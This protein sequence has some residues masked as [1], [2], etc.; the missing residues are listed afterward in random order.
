[1]IRPAVK[2]SRGPAW[3]TPKKSILR[4]VEWPHE[5]LGVENEAEANKEAED[6]EQG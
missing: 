1:M 4:R 6:A 5:R 3:E 2:Q